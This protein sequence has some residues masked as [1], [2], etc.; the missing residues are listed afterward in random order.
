MVV[1]VV[2]WFELM[3]GWKWVQRCCPS[4]LASWVKYFDRFKSPRLLDISWCGD[5]LDRRCRMQEQR[6]KCVAAI[7]PQRASP[8]PLT[9]PRL[10]EGPLH[11]QRHTGD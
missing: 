5:S 8:S 6:E 7:A 4:L 3:D 1:G 11:L 2:R 9:C 10:T